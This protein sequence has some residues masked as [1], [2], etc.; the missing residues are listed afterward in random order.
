MWVAEGTGKSAALEAELPARWGPMQRSKNTAIYLA[1]RFV[2]ALLRCLP[3]F[4]LRSLGA[5]LGTLAAW[6]VRSEVSRAMDHLKVA[7]PD[8]TPRE[9]RRTVRQM[10]VALAHSA[11]DALVLERVILDTGIPDS[12]RALFEDALSEGRGVVAVSGHIGNWELCAQSIAAA[13]FPLSVIASPTY[14]PR[15]TRL[16]HGFRSRN[17]AQVLWR[18]DRT[19]GKDMLRVFKR[20]QVLAMLID[21][22]TKVQG[23]FV[24]F[25]GKPA[26]TPIAAAQL[27]LRFKAPIIVG[28]VY[29][30]HGDYRYVF[31]RFPYPEDSTDSMLCPLPQDGLTS[32]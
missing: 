8:L 3:R 19:V 23:A 14:D 11:M 7:F 5:A 15:L 10:F 13:G 18:G 21:Q 28:F 17:G 1:I 24:P 4:V 20:N 25:F 30:H 26:H 16:I 31:E 6:V 27:A 22:D 9:A 29:H 2:V 12:A 32:L